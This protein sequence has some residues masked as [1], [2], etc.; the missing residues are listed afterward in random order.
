M[1][2]RT[3]VCAYT[4]RAQLI[5]I[6]SAHL[7]FVFVGRAIIMPHFSPSFFFRPF[8]GCLLNT[9]GMECA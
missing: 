7:L 8:V 3:K 9:R 2:R 6:P 4:A 5:K 1:R